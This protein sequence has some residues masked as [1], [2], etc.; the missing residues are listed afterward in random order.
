MIPAS[1]NHPE[2]KLQRHADKVAALCLAVLHS[3]GRTEPVTRNSAFR[4]GQLPAPLY[5][6]VTKIRGT[7]SYR[8]SD[9]DINHLLAAGYSQDAIFEITIAAALGAASERLESGLAALQ[10]AD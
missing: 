3:S 1:N 6:Y 5:E 2:Q 4:R 7:A 8:I 9:D 10:E